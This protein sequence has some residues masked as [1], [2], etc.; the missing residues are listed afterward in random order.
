MFIQTRV[1]APKRFA[2]F[3]RQKQ[4]FSVGKQR[5]K[6]LA[7]LKSDR[8][9]SMTPFTIKLSHVETAP[10]NIAHL[11][12]VGSEMYCDSINDH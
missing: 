6:R 3:G 7:K 10:D 12:E 1:S 11:G 8:L 9:Y 2:K 4:T 5:K